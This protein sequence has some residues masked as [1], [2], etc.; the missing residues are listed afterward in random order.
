MMLARHALYYSIAD[1]K[2]HV[3][4]TVSVPKREKGALL[5]VNAKQGVVEVNCVDLT[6]STLPFIVLNICPP[7]T[8]LALIHD[9]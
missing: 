7:M 3:L 9:P 4:E 1:V 5:C 2:N 6:K 8:Y